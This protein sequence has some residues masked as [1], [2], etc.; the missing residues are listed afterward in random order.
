MDEGYKKLLQ[1]LSNH[2]K[3]LS[4]FDTFGEE[5]QTEGID[6]GLDLISQLLGY[7]IDFSKVSQNIHSG[8][9][10]KTTT[11]I[12]DATSVDDSWETQMDS[13]SDNNNENAGSSSTDAGTS[14][15]N[16]GVI[17]PLIN[18]PP[19]KTPIIPQT[20]PQTFPKNDVKTPNVEE[21]NK[22]FD[23]GKVDINSKIAGMGNV[24]PRDSTI[25]GLTKVEEET[26]EKFADVYY[27]HYIKLRQCLNSKLLTV[28]G[29]IHFNDRGLLAIS[30]AQ[31][32]FINN[33]KQNLFIQLTDDEYDRLNI[34][35][36]QTES[37]RKEVFDLI[38]NRDSNY[39]VLPHKK[40]IMIYAL[41]WILHFAYRGQSIV[42]SVPLYDQIVS[43]KSIFENK[44][45][46]PENIKQIGSITKKMI[47]QTKLLESYKND[48]ITGTGIN[49]YNAILKQYQIQVQGNKSVL[50][51]LKRRDD[52]NNET[53]TVDDYLHRR[54]KLDQE[55]DSHTLP[56]TLSYNDT[57]LK[58]EDTTKE[59][60]SKD[61]THQYYYY[62]FDHV[63]GSI[64]SNADIATT[65]EPYAY[66]GPKPKN[67]EAFNGDYS[68]FVFIGYGQS[69]S[70][71]TSTLVYLDFANKDGILMELLYKL[72]PKKVKCSMIEIY[73]RQ[74]ATM[75]DTTCIGIKEPTSKKYVFSDDQREELGEELA[76]KLMKTAGDVVNC[77]PGKTGKKTRLEIPGIQLPVKAI[78]TKDKNAQGVLRRVTIGEVLD[79]AFENAG[80]FGE[81]KTAKVIDKKN[82]GN[83]LDEDDKTVAE[84]DRVGP[85]KFSY[86]HKPD[87]GGH[88]NGL[89]KDFT[90]KNYILNGFECRE[91]APTGNNKQSSRSHVVVYLECIY[92]NGK[93]QPIYVCDLAGVENVFNCDNG[94]EDILRMKAKTKGNKNYAKVDVADSYNEGF[95]N[96]RAGNMVK[97][98]HKA[99]INSQSATGVPFCFPD[100][101]P[102]D[103]GDPDGIADQFLPKIISVWAKTS[104]LYDG[105]KT[106][107][108]D[109]NDEKKREKELDGK[110]GN[111]KK[112][113]DKYIQVITKLLNLKDS[114]IVVNDLESALG[115]FWSTAN[116]TLLMHKS[117]RVLE[118]W[119]D[120]RID[121]R[122]CDKPGKLNQWKDIKFADRIIGPAQMIFGAMSSPNCV[123]AYDAGF[124]AACKIRRLE[125]YVI[126]ATL[127]EL[128]KD[129][130]RVA[131]KRIKERTEEL[132]NAKPILFGDTYDTWDKI[133]LSEHP[134][135]DWYDINDPLVSDF[136]LILTSM[137]MLK[138]R[139]GKDINDKWSKEEKLN[140]LKQF[141][142]TMVTVLNETY[143]MNLGKE[144]RSPAGNLI[145]VNN[146]PL[147]PY[148]NVSELQKKR[149]E[150]LFYKN[151][152]RKLKWNSDQKDADV[153]IPYK[154]EMVLSFKLFLSEYINILVRMYKY[155]LYQE[156]V[157]M[158]F[159]EMMSSASEL[160]KLKNE[161]DV[162]NIL[163]K[164][165]KNN[166]LIQFIEKSSKKILNDVLGNNSAT[167]IGTIETTEQVNRVASKTPNS[168]RLN[169]TTEHESLQALNNDSFSNKVFKI[170][171]DCVGKAREG[172]TGKITSDSVEPGTLIQGVYYESLYR[173]NDLYKKAEIRKQLCT[174]KEKDIYS[175]LVAIES[176]FPIMTKYI[177][178]RKIDSLWEWITKNSGM[179][180]FADG[181]EYPFPND[182]VGT[183]VFDD[184]DQQKQL[185]KLLEPAIKAGDGCIITLNELIV[186][187][188]KV[189][190][191]SYHIH[192]ANKEIIEKAADKAQGK[193]FEIGYL[194]GKSGFMRHN[195]GLDWPSRNK[196]SH[197]L[198]NLV[199]MGDLLVNKTWRKHKKDKPVISMM[200][201]LAKDDFTI[202][203]YAEFLT[204]TQEKSPYECKL[205]SKGNCP[206]KPD[207]IRYV[208][209][210][211]TFPDA[212]S[213][214]RKGRQVGS[215]SVTLN[216]EDYWTD[217]GLKQ[218]SYYSELGL[219]IWNNAKEDI[220]NM[221]PFAI[222]DNDVT[223]GG[224]YKKKNSRRKNKKLKRK[225]T[226]RKKKTNKA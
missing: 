123:E 76:N 90:A 79:K 59:N 61:F 200:K 93:I 160:F 189:E 159:K 194:D 202:N 60:V 147:P 164:G 122:E 135:L 140:Y 7:N 73:E 20:L 170:L 146:P 84:F 223:D 82:S 56:I 192:S 68:P 156:R 148:I 213:V 141:K 199:L 96:G 186:N 97:Y 201:F 183:S 108:I 27:K 52:W 45:I 75:S 214:K 219:H 204:D 145:Y 107:G 104:P 33:V 139:E 210:S 136:G 23:A 154:D 206:R 138:E 29:A 133:A 102:N 44:L 106:A 217:K 99:I 185:K 6:T 137:C 118:S 67:K 179:R 187:F 15:N 142:Y 41:P 2:S 211:L 205:D 16:T 173:I 43:N 149:E 92:E 63:F 66:I 203:V 190:P 209:P 220:D 21:S 177:D 17:D 70:G 105:V 3:F 143:I 174:M 163:E 88:V 167:Y 48:L 113:K 94:S 101:S 119:Q 222:S 172:G 165:V 85:K 151:D 19:P 114:P 188:L 168:V 157:V 100:G 134:L 158:T 221:R 32:T 40:C 109:F 4:K 181:Q 13:A 121:W 208:N 22:M 128:T 193:Y 169:L 36:K 89:D 226:R 31:K 51:L 155:D 218:T 162:E 224:N 71:K 24:K 28:I 171:Y 53:K 196:P 80:K 225:Q 153:K 81:R 25:E 58:L 182:K 216:D 42:K 126:N 1:D 215:K 110:E 77:I 166:N 116:R 111:S 176:V 127:S 152:P 83:K 12:D 46:V 120:N 180:A 198:M 125:G 95:F 161:K 87:E 197:K 54:F 38:V 62:G 55:S 86:T 191:S 91:I 103:A 131:K 178:T 74:A 26:D 98:V 112:M 130:T 195:S 50:A 49:I 37:E 9:E 39:S 47:E 14:L 124:Q 69:G 72:G 30:D 8:K 144:A 11:N 184:K 57:P 78:I 129:L 65:I 207:S 117:S 132:D 115:K 175:I 18:N 212:N 150:W 5:K 10:T 35:I 34:M 64:T